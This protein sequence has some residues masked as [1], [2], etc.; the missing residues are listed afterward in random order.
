[1]AFELQ[2]NYPDLKSRTYSGIVLD[3]K[4]L[5]PNSNNKD[6]ERYRSYGD[7][8]SIFDRSAH[9]TLNPTFVNQQQFNPLISESSKKVKPD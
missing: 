6:V 3:Q 5:I 1:M 2:K 4:W 7:L 8:V 9:S